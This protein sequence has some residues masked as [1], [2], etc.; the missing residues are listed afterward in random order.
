ML[1][2]PAWNGAF[3]E[4][5]TVH[6]L[7]TSLPNCT[8]EEVSYSALMA[9]CVLWSTGTV[10]QRAQ[11]LFQ[12]VN[13]PDEAQENIAHTDKGW[14]PTLFM[15]FEIA[16]KYAYEATGEQKIEMKEYQRIWKAM[17][18]SELGDDFKGFKDS[19]YDAESKL[20]HQEFIDK[21]A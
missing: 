13:P 11:A 10:A 6:K 1:S 4:G 14:E 16:T 5:H 9:L 18:S 7:L 2:T 19:L 8:N 12:M 3:S 21:M 15:L 20:K 17:M